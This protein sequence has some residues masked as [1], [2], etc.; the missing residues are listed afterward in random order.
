M[1]RPIEGSFKPREDPVPYRQVGRLIIITT[2][3]KF[4]G[5]MGILP[6]IRGCAI[7]TM[8]TI[9]AITKLIKGIKN[10]PTIS[11]TKSLTT[12]TIINFKR[13]KVA[14]TKTKTQWAASQ[15]ES[16]DITTTRMKQPATIIIQIKTIRTPIVTNSFIK[17]QQYPPK[18]LNSRQRE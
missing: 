17:A 12:K 3:A 6:K 9:T 13:K 15:A 18:N 2:I 7:T 16:M 4:Q 5:D 8:P 14:E 11:T 10:S 1:G